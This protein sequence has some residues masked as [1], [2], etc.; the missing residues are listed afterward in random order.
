MVPLSACHG[1]RR[2][3]AAWPRR[4]RQSTANQATAGAK[5]TPKGEPKTVVDMAK[6]ANENMQKANEEMKDQA[7]SAGDA[8]GKATKKTWDCMCHSSFA[9]EDL[10]PLTP[11]KPSTAVHLLPLP[12]PT[13]GLR[14][15]A[16]RHLA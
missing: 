3:P 8:I 6:Q 4:R 13:L 10:A 5:S 7:Q 11:P 14:N 1:R 15:L 9:A 12:R 2:R 16:F